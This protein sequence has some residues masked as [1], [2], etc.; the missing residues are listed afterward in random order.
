MVDN[1]RPFF[2]IM[3][4]NYKKLYKTFIM[5]CR[6]EKRDINDPMMTVHHILPRSMGGSDDEKNKVLL[7]PKEHYLAHRIFARTYKKNHPEVCLL[8]D[9]FSNGMKGPNSPKLS[10][11]NFLLNQI[12]V[13]KNNGKPKKEIYNAYALALHNEI[14]RLMDLPIDKNLIT[15]KLLENVI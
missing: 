15:T 3:D 12:N 4:M 14:V 9:K 6:K 10:N 2:Y 13:F 1:G 5:K 8:L 7:T 11:F